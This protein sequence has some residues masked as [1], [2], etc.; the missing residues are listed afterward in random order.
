[1]KT[2]YLCSENPHKLEEIKACVG[3]NAH[4]RLPSKLP[5]VAETGDT[6]R[7][8]ALLKAQALL[9]M[10]PKHVFALGD[11]SGLEV[12]ALKGAL[13]VRSKRYSKQGTDK[14]NCQQLLDALK[15]LPENQRGARF[16]CHLVLLA[17]GL[18]QH[19]IGS[20]EGRILKQAKGQGGFGYDGVFQPQ[21]YTQS[22]AELGSVIKNQCSARAIAC[23]A[24]VDFLKSEATL[25]R[26]R[27]HDFLSE[28][29][30]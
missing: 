29:R 11:D 28:H 7:E 6:F 10:L 22:L 16:I 18:E 4:V 1:M 17:K 8:N 23:R 27:P 19:F 26:K 9:P 3:E 15:L 24:L 30:Y 20:L 2:L 25:E 14:A 12:E 13:G 21:N 5:R